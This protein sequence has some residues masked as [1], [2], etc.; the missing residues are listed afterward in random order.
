MRRRRLLGLGVALDVV[1]V[2]VCLVVPLYSTDSGTTGGRATLLEVNGAGVLVPLALFLGLALLA[3]FLPWR[4]TRVA[5]VAA[6]GLLTLLALLSVGALFLPATLAL[7]VGGFLEVVGA[8][9]A[10]VPAR[11]RATAPTA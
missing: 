11:R 5:A 6:H 3:R 8:L 2:G 1:A 9:P 4:A 7:A 10:T